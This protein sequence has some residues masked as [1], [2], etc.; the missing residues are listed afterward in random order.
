MVACL[1]R[2][3]VLPRGVHSV[4]VSV[5]QIPFCDVA[6]LCLAAQVL[7]LYLNVE[8]LLGSNAYKCVTAHQKPS[9]GKLLIDEHLHDCAHSSEAFWGPGV[10]INGDDMFTSP[11][12][13]CA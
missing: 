1:M 10:F 4:L 5:P 8:C 12:H 3:Q 13:A 2:H 6:A 9:N 7:L 11:A